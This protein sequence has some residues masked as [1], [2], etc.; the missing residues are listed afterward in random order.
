[1]KFGFGGDIK[2][3][4]NNPVVNRNRQKI[5][6]GML[7]AGVVAMVMINGYFYSET[8]RMVDIT[9]ARVNIMRN[10][11]ITG[12]LLKKAQISY[13]DYKNSVTQ[14]K[15]GLVNK[16]VLWENA[17]KIIGY[18]SAY[19]L[20][21]DDPILYKKLTGTYIDNTKLIL[22]SFPGKVIK[23]LGVSDT[24]VTVFKKITEVGDKINIDL[25][26][27]SSMQ[28]TVG[29][30]NASEQMSTLNIDTVKSKSLFNGIMIADILNAQGESILDYNAQYNNL[31]PEQQE[32]LDADDEWKKKTT[33]Q[34]ILCA[35]TPEE[36]ELYLE[37]VETGRYKVVVSI[38]QRDDS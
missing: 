6:I 29:N 19:N 10:E 8:N 28:V 34:V 3:I 21:A 36:N 5:F 23:R 30:R 1:M 2:N 14:T 20:I 18:Y 16:Y 33:P 27:N 11:R 31:T 9:V 25:V 15:Q 38:P 24:D 12:D 35:L 32:I 13:K 7:I 4:F 17:G 37:Y 26:Y 22:Y